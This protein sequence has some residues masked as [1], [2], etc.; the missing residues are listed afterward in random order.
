[1][2]SCIEIKNLAKSF[3]QL[4][5]FKEWNLTVQPAERIVILGPSGSGKTTFLRIIAGLEKPSSG[6]ISKSFKR[7]GFVFQEPR[8]IPWRSVQ[9]NIRFVAGNES[10]ANVLTYFRLNNYENYYPSQLSGGL[11]QR[12]NLARALITN[13]DLLIMD[14]PFKSLDIHLKIGI[15][16]D[17]LTLWSD[18]K[19][20]MLTVTHDLKEAVLLADRILIVAGKPSTIVK[21]FFVPLTLAQRSIY[22]PRLLQIEAEILK[23]IMDCY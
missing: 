23:T 9:D 5:V 16:D 4:E 18:H 19:F 22:E 10:L 14:E 12:V 15:I 11:E 8:L 21:E 20:T 7:I 3:Q 13:P 17:L 6:N 1:M 2:E